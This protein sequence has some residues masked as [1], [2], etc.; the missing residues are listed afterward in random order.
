MTVVDDIE[1]RLNQMLAA[2]QTVRALTTE[3]HQAIR[4]LK[5]V[6][7]EAKD[8]VNSLAE[9]MVTKAVEDVVTRGLAAYIDTQRTAID[10]ATDSIFARFDTL[11]DTMMGKIGTDEDLTMELRKAQTRGFGLRNSV[12]KGRDAL[13]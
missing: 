3:A 1:N 6:I 9:P 2:A 11:A 8:V 12:P 13:P 7:K 10:K 4:D 5:L